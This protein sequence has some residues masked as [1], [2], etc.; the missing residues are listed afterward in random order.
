MN[1]ISEGV[2]LKNGYIYLKY[3]NH[4]RTNQEGCVKRAVLTLESKL[5]HYLLPSE[6][7]HHI[8]SIKDDDSPE[9]L[10]VL[11][12][13][14][15]GKL[16]HPRKIRIPKARI[17]GERGNYKI[18]DTCRKGHPRTAENLYIWLL[19]NGKIERICKVCARIREYNKYHRNSLVLKQK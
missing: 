2:Y 14:E 12:R 8:N 1:K 7:C 17:Y 19:P 13:A 18:S 9:N 15:H 10:T 6:H 11:T 4:P 5:G 3:P 16:H